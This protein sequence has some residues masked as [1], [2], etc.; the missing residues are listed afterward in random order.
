[1]ITRKHDKPLLATVAVFAVLGLF[2][3]IHSLAATTA[4]NLEAENGTKISPAANVSD[5]G[6]S[7]GTAVKFNAPAT[8][9]P[10][11]PGGLSFPI[12]TAFYY[13]WYPETWSVNGAHV[14]YHPTLGYYDSS[15]QTVVDSHIK[16][17][18]YAGVKMAVASWWGP[19]TQKENTRIPQIL[20]RTQ[21]LGSPLKWALYFEQEGTG[22]P[23]VAS[24]QSELQYIKTNYAGNPAYATIGGKPVLFVYNASGGGDDT[25]TVA[26]RWKQ[27]NAGYGFYVVLKLFSGFA[28]CANQPDFWHQYGPASAALYYPGWSYSISPGFWRADQTVRLARDPARWQQNVRDMVSSRAPLQIITTFNEWG[29]GTA[30]ESASEWSSA[31]GQG[32]YL[33]ALHNNQ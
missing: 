33:D 16:S 29:E 26:D 7:G 5:V 21:A 4:L 32:T 15:S 19:S 27:A 23:S 28:S 30:T 1:M 14:F 20:A 17:L 3:L 9:P 25:C 6:A 31:S 11:P 8:P 12:R 22:D 18:D 24:I 13:P 2:L 10:P